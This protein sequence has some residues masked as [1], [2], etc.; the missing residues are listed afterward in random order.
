MCCASFPSG[1]FFYVHVFIST[2]DVILKVVIQ[3]QP[4]MLL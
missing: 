1:S 3:E 2:G 4:V